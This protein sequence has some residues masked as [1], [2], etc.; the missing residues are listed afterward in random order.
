MA[1]SVI[2]SCD[3]KLER[4][5]AALEAGADPAVV[6]EWIKTTQTERAHAEQDIRSHTA[7]PR[8]G[9][10]VEQVTDLVDSLGD[11]TMALREA[12]P[13]DKAAVY[14]ELGLRLTFHPDKQMVHAQVDPS[15][16]RWEKV[17]VEG[18][19]WTPTT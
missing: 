14:R 2:A 17:C 12:T 6:T 8:P 18:P 19:S 13:E 1:R 15:V 5:R 11:L 9:M 3:A 4:Y 10:T 7:T 16:H